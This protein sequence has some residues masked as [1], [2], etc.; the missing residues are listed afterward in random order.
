[1]TTRDGSTYSALTEGFTGCFGSPDVNAGE[2]LDRGQEAPPAPT[3]YENNARGRARGAETLSP[4]RGCF[5]PLP[6]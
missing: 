4:R 5:L 2:G 1:M 6:P 3:P